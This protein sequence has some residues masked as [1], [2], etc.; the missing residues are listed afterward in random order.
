M[1]HRSGIMKPEFLDKALKELLDRG[2]VQDTKIPFGAM[3]A[4]LNSGNT[5]LIREGSIRKA[6][7]RSSLMPGYLPPEEEGAK[8]ITDGG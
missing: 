3:A 2:N 8:L 5:I 6:V 4:D 1:G 7:R